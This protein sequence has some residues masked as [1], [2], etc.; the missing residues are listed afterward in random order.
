MFRGRLKVV[1]LVVR[2]AE[3]VPRAVHGRRRAAEARCRDHDRERRR[4]ARLQLVAD[5]ADAREPT[6]HT[7][8]NVRAEPRRE[9]RVGL[10]RDEH[11]GRVCGT[12]AEPGAR[13]DALVQLDLEGCPARVGRAPGQI[14]RV[15]RYAF[16]ERAG[17]RQRRT[18]R[19]CE[20][21]RVV[22]F[23]DRD[24]RRIELVKSVGARAGDVQ[25]Q[26]ELRERVDSQLTHRRA[27]PNPRA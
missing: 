26:R 23:V 4:V 25:R 16:R 17:D 22:R 21:E 18:R 12:T 27:W 14:R 19:R 13:R 7:K 20:D 8:R 11:G 24:H 2:T 1:D 6:P 15:G 9:P 10:Q 5:A 3:L